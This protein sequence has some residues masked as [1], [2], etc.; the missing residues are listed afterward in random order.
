MNT[1]PTHENRTKR[2]E[3]S[4]RDAQE[5]GCICGIVKLPLPPPI[6]ERAREHLMSNCPYAFCFRDI[7]FE[8]SDGVLTLR[9]RVPSYYLKQILQTWLRRLDGVQ[10]IENQ[11][12]V[13]NAT[14]LSSEPHIH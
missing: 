10:Q 11:V 3:L 13:V 6:E 8:F 9:G 4:I 12:D 14:G 5:V 2:C 1:Q 7:K